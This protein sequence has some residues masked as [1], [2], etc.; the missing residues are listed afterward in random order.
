MLA[1]SEVDEVMREIVAG[2]GSGRVLT[3]PFNL[4][5]SR[6][7]YRADKTILQLI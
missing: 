7:A 6:G 3:S 1:R 4:Q 2:G 5:V